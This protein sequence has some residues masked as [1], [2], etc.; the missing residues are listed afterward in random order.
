ME[1]LFF[2]ALTSILVWPMIK[3]FVALYK[4]NKANE[5]L[6]LLFEVLKHGFL[7]VYASQT[8]KEFKAKAPAKEYYYADFA[9]DTR[10]Y[11][12]PFQSIFDATKHYTALAQQKRQ[13]T[14]AALNLTTKSNKHYTNN[15]V[16][17]NFR[18]RRRL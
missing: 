15:V 13:Q 5:S 12:G 3:F 1:L 18:N 14:L 9:Q 8:A 17:V 16:N 10:S 6:H 2:L 4:Q 7:V 11:T